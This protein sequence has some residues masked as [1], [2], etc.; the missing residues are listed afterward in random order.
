MTDEEDKIT[1]QEMI[2]MFGETMPL[3]AATLVWEAPDGMTVGDVR[4]KLRKIAAAVRVVPFNV[5]SDQKIIEAMARAMCRELC[6]MAGIHKQN[7]MEIDEYVDEGWVGCK[8][9]ASQQLAAHRA[10]LKA[11]KDT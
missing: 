5:S 9:G 11:E 6:L 3:E 7:S 8:V 2:E 4:K 10:M 1:Q